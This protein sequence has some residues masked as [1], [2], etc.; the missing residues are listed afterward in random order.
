MKKATLLLLLLSIMAVKAQVSITNPQICHD[1]SKYLRCYND[2]YFFMAFKKGDI[3]LIRTSDSDFI[4]EP[5]SKTI[6]FNFSSGK[7]QLKLLPKAILVNKGQ[8]SLLL[9]SVD[10]DS[11]KLAR[12]N[13][14]LVKKQSEWGW[15]NVYI[16]NK[17]FSIEVMAFFPQWLCD[18]EMRNV[19]HSFK[20]T[21]AVY[22][23]N[24]VEMVW[25]TD[26]EVKYNV[27]LSTS[28]RTRKKVSSL[29]AQHYVD[30]VLHTQYGDL[31]QTYPR[32]YDYGFEYDRKGRLKHGYGK[33]TMK[34]C[35]CDDLL[36][37]P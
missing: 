23:K 13:I 22:K 8:D 7:V 1:S 15:L 3:S 33:A 24:R 26:G 20:L 29:H 28:F 30:T 14:F 2:G 9:T 36:I 35:N 25:L 5:G 6:T 11:A 12:F 32:P 21:H 34:L 27:A 4:Y 37:D 17:L 31:H 19:L 18:I 10:K 16:N